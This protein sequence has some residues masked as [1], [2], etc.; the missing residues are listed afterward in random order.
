M[1]LT[2]SQR[3][4]I[5]NDYEK[6]CTGAF[7]AALQLWKTSCNKKVP[8]TWETILNVLSKPTIDKNTL[9]LT[10][11]SHLKEEI[12][13]H[14]Q[15]SANEVEDTVYC[16]ETDHVVEVS[17]SVARHIRKYNGRFTRL[18][19]D[20]CEA[21][22]K[23]NIPVKQ[24]IEVSGTS[25]DD[26]NP[27][28][29]SVVDKFKKEVSY[30]E[31]D[32]LAEVVGYYLHGTNLERD[33]EA[34]GDEI[35]KS[36]EKSHTLRDLVKKVNVECAL[37]NTKEVKLKVSTRW[38]HVTI[39][40][41]K[42]FLTVLFINGDYL[43]KMKV[44]KGCLCV[45]LTVPDN[46]DVTT[47]LSRSP[48]FMEI[49]GV[50]SLSVGDDVIFENPEPD[51]EFITLEDSLREAL[52]L[53]HVDAVEVLVKVTQPKDD[54]TIITDTAKERDDSGK[55][56]LYK[57]CQKNQKDMVAYL[58]Y[59]MRVDP[60][61]ADNRGHTPLMEASSLGHTHI[62]QLL[63]TAGANTNA[64]NSA[65]CT[66]LYLTCEYGDTDDHAAVASI[67]LDNGA[68]PYIPGSNGLMPL[69]IAVE[70][71]HHNVVNKL[72]Q[73]GVS[74]NTRNNEGSTALHIACKYN[75]HDIVTLL[76]SHGANKDTTNYNNE[77]PIDIARQRGY[78]DI[79]RLLS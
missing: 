56:L 7:L 11:A 30:V 46:V 34:Y 19:N 71:G 61:I 31:Y 18:L 67:L 58:L 13:A 33:L 44:K 70:K 52:K 24:F 78:D 68:S 75:Q 48:K 2:D 50:R 39:E 54:T 1:E 21:L 38:G 27:I 14:S 12:I 10:I 26:E 6:D 22:K 64:Q 17:Y 5:K 40:K 66:A 76:L 79:I 51:D 65:A 41:F 42:I 23:Q 28:L 62:V 16:I 20:I 25:M 47:E 43:K 3:K 72:V 4:S 74:T 63:L 49:M 53:G 55:T 9:A 35:E 36:R 45:I 29:D 32:R 37:P 77:L 8:Y 60:D 57:A 73:Q 59:D 69:M 15:V